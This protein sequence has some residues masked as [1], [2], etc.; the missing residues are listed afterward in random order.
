MTLTGV[1]VSASIEPACAANANGSISFEGD[2]P[3]RTAMTTTIGTSAATAPFTL[4]T[5]V[6]SATSSIVSTT[7]RVWL[8]PARAMS[9]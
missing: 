7:S 4:I 3:R 8:V 9:C 1:P 6:S 2:R 5:A